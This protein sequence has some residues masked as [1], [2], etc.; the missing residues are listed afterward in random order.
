MS[1]L[2]SIVDAVEAEIEAVRLI[3]LAIKGVTM[4]ADDKVLLVSAL[5]SHLI[6]LE[7]IDEMAGGDPQA[8]SA[9]A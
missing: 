2:L 5:E 8:L 9:A 7:E 1:K 3:Q 6:K 4:D